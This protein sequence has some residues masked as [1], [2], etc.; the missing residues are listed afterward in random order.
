MLGDINWLQPTIW[1]KTQETSNLFQISQDDKDLN[2][3][4]KLS[5]EGEKVNFSRKNLQNIYKD[6]LDPQLDC[7]LVILISMHFSSEILVQRKDI[8][9]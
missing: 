8:I 2:S 5:V 7:I 1:L 4:W 3:P 9:L 6:S